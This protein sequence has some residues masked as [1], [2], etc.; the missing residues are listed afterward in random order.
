MPHYHFACLK[1]DKANATQYTTQKNS[2][3]GKYGRRISG[4]Y[5][6]VISGIPD[7]I[8]LRALTITY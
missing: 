5:F 3:K 1:R 6:I 8:N 2:Q 4:I 7:M